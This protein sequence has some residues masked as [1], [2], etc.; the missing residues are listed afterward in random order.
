MAPVTELSTISL[1]ELTSLTM[2]RF[3][4]GPMLV[5]DLAVAESLFIKE[6]VPQNTGSTRVYREIDG[7]TY[8]GYKG[9]GAD[10]PKK[11]VVEGYNVTM[12]KRRFAA[13]I[14]ITYE[15][16]K[17]NRHPEVVAKLTDLAK[18]CPQRRALDLT[19]IFTFCTATSYTDMDGETVTTSV[20]DSLA[21]VSASHTLTGS[22]STY[23]NVITGNPTFSKGG[24]QV[25]RKQANSQILTNF[26][27]RRVMN[28]DCIITGDDPATIDAVEILLRS[29]T[30][31]TQNNSGVVNTYQGRAKHVV[32]PR[33]ATTA[34]GAR[35]TDKDKYWG[36]AA[37]SGG[38]GDRWQA[39]LGIWEADNLKTPA[40]GN[41]GED[42]HNDNWTFGARG[43][44]GIRAVSGRGLLW[45]TGLGA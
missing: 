14:D 32:L 37:T 44:W 11:R 33:L 40:P 39:Y 7:E 21:L 31:P 19:H 42:V 43:G 17:E 18:F 20:G 15:M 22:T 10:A 8:A 36:Y 24:F 16:R 3:V 9:E 38:P 1:S 12:T 25:A 13:E 28:F 35:D 45:S 26:G 4:E 6:T 27:E 23:S 34:T 30:D 2:Q 29:T 41:N 5:D